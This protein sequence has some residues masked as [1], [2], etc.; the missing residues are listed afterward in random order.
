MRTTSVTWPQL[1]AAFRQGVGV[2][3]WLAIHVPS[4]NLVLTSRAWPDGWLPSG[5][6]VYPFLGPT[7]QGVNTFSIELADDRSSRLGTVSCQVL[8]TAGQ[9]GS[10]P[11][12]RLTVLT[13]LAEQEAFVYGLLRGGV[14]QTTYERC[15]LFT[16][17]VSGM[18]LTRGILSFT[19]VD[20]VAAEH[21][22]LEIPLGSSV[23]PGSPTAAHGQ[24]VPLIFGTALGLEPVLV[25]GDAQGTLATPL[26]A[27][28]VTTI[29]LVETAAP[30]P[31]SG[32][33]TIDAET[34]TY[35]G[36]RLGV[37]LN[38]QATL[39]L[40]AP[41]RSAPVAHAAG[42]SVTLAAVTYRY[43]L[44]TG[45]P[46]L[47]VL[48]VRDDAGPVL[49]YTL[50]TDPPG[51]PAGT[52][53][54]ETTS[55]HTA[56]QVDVQAIPVPPLPPLLNG[57]FE[58]GALDGWTVEAGTT[59]TVVAQE[60]LDGRYKLQLGAIPVG[61]TQGIWQDI[62]VE[63]GRRYVV[64]LAWRTPLET[65]ANVV[66]NGAFTQLTLAPWVFAQTQGQPIPVTYS[67]GTGGERGQV[68]L[69]LPPGPIIPNAGPIPAP[70]Q[71]R[72]TLTQDSVAVLPGVMHTLAVEVWAFAQ[73]PWWIPGG[74][75]GSL[76]GTYP[77]VDMFVRVTD[78]ATGT[79]Q[80]FL[81]LQGG[82]LTA[83]A[84]SPGQWMRYL[85]QGQ[86]TPEGATVTLTLTLSGHYWGTL[87]PISVRAI[88]LSATPDA[89]DTAT[90]Q[91]TGLI[92][93]GLP[94]APEHYA[95]LQ[96]S[97]SPNW[98]ALDV[99]F[100]A[101][102]A[103]LRL[104]LRGQ[105]R[106]VDARV[107]Y[108]S[109]RFLAPGRNPVTLMAAVFARFLPH[110]ALNQASVQ[111]AEARRQSWLF[112]GY[113]PDPGRTDQLL[114]TMAQASWCTVFKD[115]DGVYQITAEDPDVQ[116]VLSLQADRDVV[117]ESLGLAWLPM[118][119]VYT[120]FYLWYGRVTQAT[121]TVPAGQYAAV[122]YVTPDASIS[123]NPDLQP[124]CQQVAMS[125]RTR[126]RFDYYADVISDPPTA[127]RLLTRLVQQLAVLPEELTLTT[128]VPA[129]PLALTDRVQVR[130]GLL[131]PR[132]W[133]GDVRQTT[134]TVSPG[135]PGL[136]VA[137]R[138]RR[139][140]L[141]RGVWEEWEYASLPPTLRV[142][143][144]WD[145]V[146]R[147]LLETWESASP[148]AVDWFL[149]TQF[150]IP[151]AC[152]A[153]LAIGPEQLDLGAGQRL[154]QPV[155]TP[156]AGPPVRL[157]RNSNVPSD[158]WSLGIGPYMEGLCSAMAIYEGEV[159]AALQPATT[160]G[161][162]QLW[163]LHPSASG[164]G[165]GEVVN[166]LPNDERVW[167]MGEYD[168]S[169][170]RGNGLYLGTGD[171]ARL[172]RWEPG[173]EP[174]VHI[175]EGAF[176]RRFRSLAI[177]PA[178]GA[179]WAAQDN[180]LADGVGR[181]VMYHITALGYNAHTLP[182]PA[183]QTC[184]M[185]PFDGTLW[186]ATGVQDGSQISVWSIT[187]GIGLVGRWDR[188][189]TFTGLTNQQPGVLYA[190]GDVLYLGR[191]STTATPMLE[192][193]RSTDPANAWSLEF[194]LSTI[195]N[196]GDPDRNQGI[197]AMVTARSRL[198]AATSTLNDAGLHNGLRVYCHPLD[199]D[200]V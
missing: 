144:P 85:A 100:V 67:Q 112:G 28:P 76:S 24:A 58:S 128:S 33:L 45:V 29:D 115:V 55:A 194:D 31:D 20:G 110:L 6:L 25:A 108:D 7:G 142:I 9:V 109:V 66:P 95:S 94:S 114:V 181:T 121:T 140:G 8:V 32:T 145:Q 70:I 183:T 189:Y 125:L 172:Y 21:R 180:A 166:T 90:L 37:L 84:L 161:V 14:S 5:A 143:E 184:T 173:E 12:P 44:G 48:A 35:S 74:F 178:T 188:R 2:E 89:D 99:G 101:E 146:S 42:S 71:F 130:G 91:A 53:V 23:F 171:S 88:L 141:R 187:P 103:T 113:L 86:I 50:V 117:R 96:S 38:G 30:F 127:D 47:E 73:P 124:L 105:A 167:A 135:P 176:M 59:A 82:A 116:P 4:R 137:V 165:T 120:D 80:A 34:L 170:G 155:N 107:E 27:T 64:H 92:A 77:R 191:I 139:A 122:L 150:G 148:P 160:P 46:G 182:A 129:I 164:D 168:F 52:V 81:Q 3:V 186:A 153:L 136:A 65:S 190:V 158:L 159:Y 51:T 177:D 162:S 154:T 174:T 57:G 63:P 62:A 157:Y 78:T 68:Q 79:T 106:T 151:D 61:T 192:L 198:Y 60:V 133:V 10:P 13:S 152:Y 83:P 119:E 15:T 17:R 75:A 16:G 175:S 126:K 149:Q 169:D 11:D 131:G 163:R 179:L 193:W 39:Q 104:T 134:L 156:R 26:S 19:L 49:A 43:L 200:I 97:G 40:L 123:A 102:Q 93:M 41:V 98:E 197:T 195:P 69:T 72:V 22:D 18:A 199:E 132:P 196:F 1:V 185:A 54:L 138:L 118:D 87:P 147:T 56:L 36:R 111:A